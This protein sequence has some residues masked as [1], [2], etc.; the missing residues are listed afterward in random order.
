MENDAKVAANGSRIS[1]DYTGM[2]EDGTVFDTS[3]GRHPI[4]FTVG[5][6]DVV[7]GFDEAVIG[8][9]KGEQKKITILPENGY[10]ARDERLKQQV[11]RSVFPPEMKLDKGMG[12][13]FKTPT[14]QVIHATISGT[15]PETVTV[16]MNHPLAGRNL[17][18]ELKI[19]DIN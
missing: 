10:G 1:V 3:G 12:F 13:S 7:K 8:M 15:N 16:D 9:K 6:G 11:P 19:V 5:N 2:F 4:E 18:F 14:G 17:V